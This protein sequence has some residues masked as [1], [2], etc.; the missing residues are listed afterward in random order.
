MYYVVLHV[1]ISVSLRLPEDLHD[2]LKEIAE[3]I[4]RSKSFLI[5]KA[6]ERYLEEYADY[7]IALERSNDK[8]D[9][10]ISS[11]ELRKRLASNS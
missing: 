2:Q 7:R 10:V 8:D 9:E 11:K 6:I 5:K 1:P 4:E 3:D